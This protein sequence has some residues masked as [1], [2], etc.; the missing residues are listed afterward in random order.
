MRVVELIGRCFVAWVG[1]ISPPTVAVSQCPP[2]TPLQPLLAPP[3]LWH[4]CSGQARRSQ[5]SCSPIGQHEQDHSPEHLRRNRHQ[6]VRLWCWP[7]T[8]PEVGVRK[9]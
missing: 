1:L 7:R 5:S 2:A 9:A 4:P 8:V 6:Q 3:F